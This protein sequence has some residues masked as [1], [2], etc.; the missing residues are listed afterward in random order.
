MKT[1]CK[2]LVLVSLLLPLSAASALG[3]S[4]HAKFG[5]VFRDKEFGDVLSAF[6]DDQGMVDYKGLKASDAQFQSYLIDIAGLYTDEYDGW[7]KERQF[8]FW[9]NTYNALTLK[10]I[11]DHYPIKSNWKAKLLYPVGIRHI[12]GAWKEITHTIK[13]EQYTLDQI[14]HEILREQFKDPRIHV[15]LVCA[16]MGC[17]PLRNEFFDVEKIDQQ[18]DDQIRDFIANP[19]KFKIDHNAHVVHLSSIFKWFGEDFLAG[20]GDK[21]SVPWGSPEEK[22]VMAYLKPFLSDQDW[23]S[24]KD[25]TYEVK[26]LDYDWA[27]NEQGS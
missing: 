21:P 11:L 1:F 15:A 10:V 3:Q 25:G 20:Y 7:E 9:I 18:L 26:Y 27:L 16:A 14:E 6:V 13:G 19:S 5:V 23:T 2:S 22:A 17:P 12:P 4:I 24:L 8:V